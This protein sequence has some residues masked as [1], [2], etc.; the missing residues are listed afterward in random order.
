[1]GKPLKLFTNKPALEEAI[2]LTVCSFQI[3]TNTD[4]LSPATFICIYKSRYS[5][6]C[7]TAMIQSRMEKPLEKMVN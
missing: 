7:T 3:E 2:T 4:D 1:M 6:T 5:I